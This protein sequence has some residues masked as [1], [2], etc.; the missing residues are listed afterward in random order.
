MKKFL[1]FLFITLNALALKAEQIS[2]VETNGSWVNL[3]DSQGKK[4]K[5]LSAYTVGTVVG[6]SSNFFVS[7]NGS[8]IYLWNPEGKKYQTLSVS[9]VGEVIGVAGDT[10]T[11]RNGNWIYTY[12][13]EGKK[14]NSR[15]AN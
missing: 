8:W 1:L 3:Y 11:T 12:N 13:K 15:Y 6:Y 9:S 4:Y 5:T 10:F 2:N 14:V 7:K